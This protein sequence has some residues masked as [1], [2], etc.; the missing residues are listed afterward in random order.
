M[1][2]AD[3]PPQYLIPAE[4]ESTHDRLINWARWSRDRPATHRAFSIEGRFRPEI[5]RGDEEEQRRHAT[6]PVDIRDALL[7]YRALVPPAFPREFAF[8]LAAEYIYRFEPRM[9]TGYLRRHGV[10][11]RDRELRAQVSRAMYAARASIK[12]HESIP[13]V[14]IVE[15]RM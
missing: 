13:A 5:L 6:V 14:A 1:M 12:R 10:R 11:V 9:M 7:V 4:L 8:T 15:H 3:I 2:I